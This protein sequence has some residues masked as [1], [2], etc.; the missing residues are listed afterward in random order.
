VKR[1]RLWKIKG[2][3]EVDGNKVAEAEILLAFAP[4][5]PATP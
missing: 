1:D 4:E 5:P 2:R 3:C